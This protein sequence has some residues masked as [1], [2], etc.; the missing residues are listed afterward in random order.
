[1]TIVSYNYVL[2][3]MFLGILKVLSG[4]SIVKLGLLPCGLG[5]E[6]DLVNMLLYL[7][8]DLEIY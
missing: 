2:T 4:S 8:L 3:G 5:L 6:D 7:W 1:M